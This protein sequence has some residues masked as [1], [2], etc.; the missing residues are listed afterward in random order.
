[1]SKSCKFCDSTDLDV[2]IE[3]A[4]K[5]SDGDVEERELGTVN[6]VCMECNRE[7]Y[8]A[9]EDLPRDLVASLLN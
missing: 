6:A 1:M 7:Q 5:I 3:Y 8:L 9:E 4:V 2:I